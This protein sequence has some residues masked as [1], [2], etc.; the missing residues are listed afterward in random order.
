MNFFINQTSLREFQN[1]QNSLKIYNFTF[2]IY[3]TVSIFTKFV[4]N[5]IIFLKKNK[6][7]YTFASEK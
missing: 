3:K 1:L 5:H 6:I 7:L 4:S 2:N